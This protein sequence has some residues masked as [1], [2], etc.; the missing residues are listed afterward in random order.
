MFVI[1][2]R[3]HIES[4]FTADPEVLASESIVGLEG[5]K[6]VDADQEDYQQK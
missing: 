3:N 5:E 2:I 6:A 1:T 4:I